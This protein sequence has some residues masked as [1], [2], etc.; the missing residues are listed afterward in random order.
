MLSLIFVITP[1]EN[2]KFNSQADIKARFMNLKRTSG[3][4]VLCTEC[5]GGRQSPPPST[6]AIILSQQ[7]WKLAV[8]PLCIDHQSAPQDQQRQ[9][10]FHMKV[11]GDCWSS[12]ARPSLICPPPPGSTV[13]ITSTLIIDCL[14]IEHWLPLNTLIIDPPQ[15]QQCWLSL[16]W[17]LITST[18]SVDC[19]YIDQQCWS[20]LC[21]LL[22]DPPYRF[23][24]S[25]L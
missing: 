23:W 22:I 12:L 19:L 20:P 16:H 14:Y 11:K 10:P 3:Q 15:D 25:N 5:L 7:K 21:W 9:L 8:D 2:F 1:H 18:L 4:P 6:E 17:S 13:L 24:L